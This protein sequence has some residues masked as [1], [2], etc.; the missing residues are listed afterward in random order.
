M[1]VGKSVAAPVSR[2][3]DPHH[4]TSAGSARRVRLL[5]RDWAEGRSGDNCEYYGGAIAARVGG[6]AS[7]AICTEPVIVGSESGQLHVF[8]CL[9]WS[10]GLVEG[11]CAREWGTIDML[12][13]FIKGTR[14]R[15]LG[16]VR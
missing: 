14:E 13:I 12:N 5:R 6:G 11:C 3:R 9:P 2:Q 7:G 10:C 4:A 16:F 1:C 8:A 15:H